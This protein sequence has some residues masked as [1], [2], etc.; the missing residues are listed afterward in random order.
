MGSV[1]K[2]NMLKN[3]QKSQVPDRYTATDEGL[4]WQHVSSSERHLEASSINYTEGIPLGYFIYFVI[5]SETMGGPEHKQGTI[6]AQ[7]RRTAP[8]SACA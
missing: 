3:N 6:A 2:H 7:N 8:D 5:I 1:V 4:I